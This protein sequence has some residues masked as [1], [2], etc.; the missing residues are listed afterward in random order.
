MALP[1]R[2][3]AAVLVLMAA[4]PAVIH[5][6]VPPPGAAPNYLGLVDQTEKW[7]TSDYPGKALDLRLHTRV[8]G[9]FNGAVV[10]EREILL[11]RDVIERHRLLYERDVEGDVYYHGDLES[12]LLPEPLLWVDAPL[13]PGKTW[14]D[15]TPAYDNGIEP[16]LM[17]HYVFAC[18][19]VE[20][21]NC[22]LGLIPTY[23]VFV[24]TIRPDGEITN[25][26]FWY[27]EQCGMVRCCLE[28]QRIY[29]LHK[30]IRP[31]LD[32]PDVELHDPLP[33]D[34][35]LGSFGSP[36][37][38]NPSTSV[39]FRLGQAAEVSLHIYDLSGRLV[40]T[41]ADEIPMEA[42]ERSLTWNGVDDAGRGLASGIYIYRLQTGALAE[43]GR[44]TVVR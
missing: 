35:G 28:N 38:A 13:Y 25:C 44:L 43:T 34:S 30:V 24:A 37:P 14:T 19:E 26:N 12:R 42:G 40:R 7:F 15:A 22:P 8:N 1:I 33:N 23:R 11:G 18:L 21:V 5:S 31:D 6:E 2:F 17:I 16:D 36:N 27:N 29:L 32:D 4:T 39:R 10:E 3:A 41:V 20:N 9:T